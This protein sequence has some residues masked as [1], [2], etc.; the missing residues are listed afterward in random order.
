[1]PGVGAYPEVHEVFE[2]TRVQTLCLV[3]D[4]AHDFVLR[5][6]REVQVKRFP[7]SEGVR[8][9]CR[10]AELMKNAF[11]KVSKPQAGEDNVGCPHLLIQLR[12]QCADERALACP[13]VSGDDRDTLAFPDPESMEVSASAWLGVR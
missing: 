8:S 12:E 3:D 9:P 11:Q 13:R 5:P 4:D 6:L 1:V 2:D 7:K 10:D